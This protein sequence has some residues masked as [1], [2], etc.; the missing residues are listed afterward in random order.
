MT[1][2]PNG[3]ANARLADICHINPRVDKSQ[4][5][6]DDVVAFVPMPA[7]EAETGKID[8]SDKRNFAQ[9]KQGYGSTTTARMCITR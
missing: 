2:L 3:W 5:G 4:F 7:V 9:V 1:E 8:V 6:A